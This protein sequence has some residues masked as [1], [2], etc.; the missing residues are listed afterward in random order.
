MYLNKD[1]KNFHKFVYSLCFRFWL[2]PIVS[3]KW[4][5]K[6]CV[7]LWRSISIC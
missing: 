3:S 5:H 7:H 1:W 6:S 4:N 2:L